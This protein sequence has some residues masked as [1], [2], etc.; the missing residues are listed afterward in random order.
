MESDLEKHLPPWERLGVPVEIWHDKFRS[1]GRCILQKLTI[2]N[3]IGS[4]K[5]KAMKLMKA[6]EKDP[7]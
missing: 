7:N 2:L 4:A 1:T 3:N 6:A 5:K